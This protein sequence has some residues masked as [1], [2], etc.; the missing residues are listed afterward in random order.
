MSI[1]GSLFG[2]ASVFFAALSNV[3]CESNK[4][5]TVISCDDGT[6]NQDCCPAE[7]QPG[8]Q[9]D[10]ESQQCW[11]KCGSYMPGLRGHLV[12]NGGSW[13]GGSGLFMCGS[14]AGVDSGGD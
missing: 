10:H 2:L 4:A 3:S 11:T 8:G 1:A 9:C 7:V 13:N 14:D 5:I 12:C 6:G